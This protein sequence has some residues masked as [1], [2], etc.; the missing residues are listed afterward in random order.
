MWEA[1]GFTHMK[2]QK[3]IRGQRI[4]A[5]I[6]ASLKAP[7]YAVLLEVD[8]GS[9]WVVALRK[10][11]FGNSYVVADPFY[12]DKCDV[13]RRYGNITGSAHFMRI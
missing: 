3:R 7:N 2:F 13:I 1:L 5:A 12:G 8:N 11:L 10:T 4:D 9:H 6:Q